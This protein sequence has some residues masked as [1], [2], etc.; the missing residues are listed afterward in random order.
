MPNLGLG[1]SPLLTPPTAIQTVYGVPGAILHLR[2]DAGIT[3]LAGAVSAW[4]DQTAAGNNV[5]QS[6]G[7]LKPTYSAG[8]V[9]GLPKIAFSGS[10][11]TGGSFSAQNSAL[12]VVAKFHDYDAT[13]VATTNGSFGVNTGL[14]L[15]FNSADNSALARQETNVGNRDVDVASSGAPHIDV[16]TIFELESGASTLTL[17]ANGSLIGATTDANTN[18]TATKIIIGALDNTG[19]FAMNGD[20]YEVLLFP[21]TLTAFERGLV[22]SALGSKYAISVT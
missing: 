22:K 10:R 8:G 1:Y 21:R 7:G 17:Y 13:A 18:D 14:A 15:A 3:Q 12:F 16:P 6:S 11:M 5:S 4:A 9:N 20:L 19:T 2:S